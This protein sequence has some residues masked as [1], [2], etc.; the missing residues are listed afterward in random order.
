MKQYHDLL[1]ELLA[2]GNEKGDRTG[3]GTLS[4]FGHQMRFNLNELAVVSFFHKAFPPPNPYVGTFLG[5]VGAGF[6]LSFWYMDKVQQFT[7]TDSE[8]QNFD[9]GVLEEILYLL[10]T[11]AR[12]VHTL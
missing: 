6:M 7:L 12:R 10:C 4:K 2:S 11:Q 9:S 5:L 1:R 8:M 3:T